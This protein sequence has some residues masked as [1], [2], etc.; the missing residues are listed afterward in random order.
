MFPVCLTAVLSSTQS[1]V[2]YTSTQ[3]Q[4]A[5]HNQNQLKILSMKRFKRAVWRIGI[6]YVQCDDVSDLKMR[7]SWHAYSELSLFVS[8]R[9][10][11]TPLQE[12]GECQEA[13][14]SC[15]RLDD[16]SFFISSSC[17]CITEGAAGRRRK[18]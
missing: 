2:A 18:I 3:S 13:V 10:E 17:S 16:P 5:M 12:V 7:T 15:T 9:S 8:L 1:V 4:L 14:Q 6:D 11:A